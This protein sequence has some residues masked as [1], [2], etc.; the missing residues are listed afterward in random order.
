MDTLE[1]R[2]EAVRRRM[3]AAA[4]ASG[5]DPSK[6]RLVAVCKGQEPDA[7][8]AAVAAGMQE[9]G[10]NYLQEAG[11]HMD[12]APGG[13]WHFIGRLQSNKTRPVAERF[14][15]VQTVDRIKTAHRLSSH[16]PE[17]MEPLQ[18][19]IQVNVDDDPAKAGCTPAATLELAAAIAAL[20]RLRLRGLMTIPHVDSDV[21]AYRR[22]STLYDA[23][24]DHGLDFDTL[25]MGMSAD[26][27]AAIA[28]GSTMVRIGTALFGPRS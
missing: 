10:E 21:A 26:F 13:V 7:V 23:C 24:C 8:R 22:M 18:V 4:A 15:W 16:R 20:P 5:R 9:F 6:I 12:A 1:A 19:C 14:D 3:A 11:G 28:A 2:I 17:G 27:E 25:S